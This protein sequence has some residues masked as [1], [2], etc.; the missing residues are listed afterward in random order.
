VLPHV[1]QQVVEHLT[2]PVEVPTNLGRSVTDLHPDGALGLHRPC[3]GAG[4]AERGG[5][6]VADV[7][8]VVDDEEPAGG[9]GGVGGL[10]QD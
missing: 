5:D 1:G 2:E 3:R 4:D 7:L 10:V 9:A 6:Q 8:L